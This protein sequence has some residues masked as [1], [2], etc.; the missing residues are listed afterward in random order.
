MAVRHTEIAATEVKTL[1]MREYVITK[2]PLVSR[3]VTSNRALDLE[4]CAPASPYEIA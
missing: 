2:N 1:N 4:A 3:Y